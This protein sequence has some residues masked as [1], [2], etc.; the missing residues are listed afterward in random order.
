MRDISFY[1]KCIENSLLFRTKRLRNLSVPVK[2]IVVQIV[3]V[4]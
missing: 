3:A 2:R 4:S 1:P